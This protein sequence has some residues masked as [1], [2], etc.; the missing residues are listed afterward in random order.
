MSEESDRRA[1]LRD[2][3]EREAQASAGRS[4]PAPGRSTLVEQLDS[5]RSE[6]TAGVPGKATLVGVHRGPDVQQLITQ[7]HAA[8]AGAGNREHAYNAL[9]DALAAQGTSIGSDRA[10]EMMALCI[11][12]LVKKET[13]PQPVQRKSSGAGPSDAPVAV[14]ERGVEGAGAP[15][16]HLDRIQRAFG[17]HD[18][19]HVRTA[20]GGAAAESSRALGASAYAVG[21][22]VGFASSPDLHTAAHEAA[23]VLQQQG[24]VHLK[25]GID[26][27]ANDPHEQHA[28]AVADLVVRGE[29]AEALLDPVAGNGRGGS[30]VQRKGDE[31]PGSAGL[32]PPTWEYCNTHRIHIVAA[33]ADRIRAVGLPV[34]HP[35][36]SWGQKAQQAFIDVLS[37]DIEL[38]KDKTLHRLMEYSYPADLYQIVDGVRRGASAKQLGEWHAVVGVAIA[39]AMTEPLDRSI[40]RMALRLRVQLDGPARGIPQDAHLVPSCPLDVRV[41]E[42]L[43]TPGVIMGGWVKSKVDDAQAK[44]LMHGANPVHFRFVDKDP[45]LWNWIEVTSPKNATPEDVASTE[46]IPGD[47]TSVMGAAQAYRIAASPPF[48]GIPIEVAR[49]VPEMRANASGAE[50]LDADSGKFGRVADAGAFHKSKAS[51]DAAKDQAP[52]AEPHTPGLEQLLGRVDTQLEAIETRLARV[53][54]ASAIVPAKD[55]AK[56]R[57]DQLATDPK[58]AKSFVPAVAAQEGILHAVSSELVDL[59]DELDR[60]RAKHKSDVESLPIS[61]SD[62]I[63]AYARAAGASHLSAESTPLL[64]DARRQKALLP[65]SVVDDEIRAARDAVAAQGESDEPGA[66]DNVNALPRAMTDA[67]N[68]RVRVS[69]GE[70]VSAMEVAKVRSDGS[71]LAMRARLTTLATTAQTLK[72]KANTVGLAAG[73]SPG[74]SWSVQMLT[75]MILDLVYK[76]EKAHSQGEGADKLHGGWMPRLDLAAKKVAEPGQTRDPDAMWMQPA[77]KY[78]NGELALMD[79][80]LGTLKAFIKWCN[81]QVAYQQL[82]NLLNSLAWQMGLMI[83]TGE[84]AGAGMAAIRG[85]ALAGEIAEDVRG[86][87]LLWRGAEVLVHSGMQTV[88]SGASGGEISGSAF[89]ENALGML[90]TSAAMKPFKG[91]LEGD[92][93]LER[94]VE[95]E[96]ST[97]GK[98]G[99]VVKTGAKLG[100]EVAI[101]L[102][103]GVIGSGVARAVVHNTEMGVGS[104][105]EWMQQ[106]IALAASAFVSAHTQGM[107]ARIEVAAREFR[108]AKMNEAAEQLDALAARAQK[109]QTKAAANKHP[110]PDEA[111]TMLLERHGILAAEHDVYQKN[112]GMNGADKKNAADLAA[113]NASFIEVPF[114][115]NGLSSVVDGLSFEGT[116]KHIGKAFDAASHNGIELIATQDANGVWTVKAGDRV[117]TVKELDFKPG[118]APGHYPAQEAHS[119]EAKKPPGAKSLPRS[120]RLAAETDAEGRIAIA[121]DDKNLR[122]AAER[123]KPEPG[124][125]DVVVHAD[126]DHFYVVHGHTEIALTH[127][128]VAKVLEKAGLKKPIKLRL[129]AC[130]AG[131]SPSAVAQHLANKTGLDVKAATMKVWVDKE[132]TVGV[133]ARDQHQGK[134]E[135]FR[136]G[137][138]V[139]LES[140][141]PMVMPEDGG[142]FDPHAQDHDPVLHTEHDHRDRVEAWNHDQL[143]AQVGKPL[144]LDPSLRDGVRIRVRKVDR[145]YE[146]LGVDYGPDTRA[147]D[148]QRHGHIVAQIEQYNTLVG[149][150]RNWNGALSGK[151]APGGHDYARGSRGDRLHLELEKL[152]QHIDD[153]NLMRSN[154]AI[155]AVRAQQEVDFLTDAVA[156]VREQLADNIDLNAHDDQFDVHRP[157]NLRY[158]TRKA[159]AEGYKLPGEGGVEIEGL[160]EGVTVDEKSYY[161]RRP[162]GGGDGYE[163]ARIPGKDVPQIE[164]I[165]G[166]AGEFRGLRVAGDGEPETKLIDIDVGDAER[167]LFEGSLK[168]YTKMLGDLQIA[169]EAD[170]R[171]MVRHQ[172]VKLTATNEKKAATSKLETLRHAVK[173]HFARRVREILF[174]PSLSDAQ[175]YRR[176]RSAVDGLANKDRANLVEQ[177]YAARRLQGMDVKAQQPYTVER[178]G[179]TNAGHKETR[180]ADFLVS[181]AHVHGKEIVEIKDIDGAI[182]Q[183]QFGAY[184]DALHDD[185][186]RATFGA[187]RMRYVFTKEAGAAANLEY[188]ADSYQRHRLDG[189]L[190]IEVYRRDGSVRTVSTKAEALQLL[191]DLRNP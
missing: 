136:P 38:A 144:T 72:N 122:A 188:L 62:L 118:H 127:R 43:T 21:D 143:Q 110:K 39:N 46:L 96:L 104:R 131:R 42:A 150:I 111:G 52:P 24:G 189:L 145:G 114:Q 30:V 55:F 89:A 128:T 178:T 56:R 175:S 160:P 138:A 14:A 139:E 148:V 135:P 10:G 159:Q 125:V 64:A 74:G 126:P 9:V 171:S 103:A 179:G 15:L 99:K 57:R 182:D 36:L 19:S 17:R 25:G 184:A 156:E 90:L 173:E 34:P 116:A 81:E 71:E 40:Q 79:S 132:G 130:E 12:L 101:D 115:L 112:G 98:I 54:F 170:V 181:Q 167:M 153:T 77:I 119:N 76:E 180:A 58:A 185:K 5:S 63:R 26:G 48:F 166:S 1:R 147:I 187:E 109:L 121:G 61:V 162:R 49:K 92:A 66:Q 151:R 107:H 37:N 157:D 102:G 3:I 27:G 82:K 149:K 146:V 129:L 191:K 65:L 176:L 161:Y 168:P 108:Q 172:Y 44:H 152:Q 31:V 28:D 22:R 164:A 137:E 80:Q 78:I 18:V 86:A 70:N 163:L 177:W 11:D 29:S 183:E 13:A 190:T 75:D 91:L 100:A 165:V 59:F 93:A 169:T 95:K 33:I 60:R 158:I 94:Q 45:T 154:D 2:R 7:G 47:S 141:R 87:G 106:G 68:M 53:K 51:D 133:G 32:S 20:T 186:V 6:S 67:A 84:I 4:G 174:D 16:P 134:W 97:L 140:K 117:L 23:H 142:H 35:T 124:Y 155:D 88:A 69:R 83:V 113:T 41:G 120:E 8:M 50:L 105:D 73:K 123:A 85:I